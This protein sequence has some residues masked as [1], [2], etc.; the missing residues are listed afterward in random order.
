MTTK[1]NYIDM[2]RTYYDGL[3][4]P[5]D[6][7]GHWG[8]HEQFPY[9]KYLLHYDGDI[10]RP[11]FQT[12][13]DKIALDFGCGPGRMI[14]RMSPLFQRVDGADISIRLINIAKTK[15]PNSQFY[16]TNGG[17]VGPVSLE[18][19]DLIYS[20][21]CMQH[22]ASRTIR[23]MILESMSRALKPNGFISIQ[24]AYHSTFNEKPHVTWDIDKFDAEK[25]NAGCDVIVNDNCINLMKEDFA[26]LFSDV[27]ISFFQVSDKYNNFNGFSHSQY[28]PSHWIFIICKKL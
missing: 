26:S 23:K 24:L 2:Q 25:T 19:Y 28:W 7:V 5:E 12:T 4:S 15:Y 20:S 16:L 27:K 21:I 17:D 3:D 18:S 6:I 10:N 1:Q 22:I 13:K 11:L 8:W 14:N 9:E